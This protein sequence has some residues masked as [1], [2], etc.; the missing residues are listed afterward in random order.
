MALGTATQ[1][2]TALLVERES[3]RRELEAKAD[4]DA[5][6]KS[7]AEA[8]FRSL[9]S[10][11]W[12]SIVSGALI[13]ALGTVAGASVGGEKVIHAARNCHLHHHLS[14]EK[15]KEGCKEAS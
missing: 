9:N 6:K 4:D 10:G 11:L 8:I 14:F 13:V 12:L 7:R 1:A 2:D 15:K 3:L 5:R